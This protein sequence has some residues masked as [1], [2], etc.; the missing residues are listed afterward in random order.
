MVASSTLPVPVV[1]GLSSIVDRYDGFILDLWGVLHDG[2]RPYPGAV[3]ALRRL[4]AAG[5]RT[6][7]LSNG[8]RRAAA[9]AR[10]TAAIGI[11][12][13]LYDGLPSSAAAPRPSP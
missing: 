9:V 8:P 4:K 7:I 1:A 10:R 5:K 2:V 3:D 12:P 11:G 6:V 13:D